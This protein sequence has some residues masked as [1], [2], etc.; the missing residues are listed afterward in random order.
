MTPGWKKRQIVQQI[1]EAQLLKDLQESGIL[2][3]TSDWM[4]FRAIDKKQKY[5]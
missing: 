1:F 4:Y 3:E 2:I 5:L